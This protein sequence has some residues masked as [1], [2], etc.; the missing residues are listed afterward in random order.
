MTNKIENR[1]K[2]RRGFGIPS[3]EQLEEYELGYSINN[4]QLYI[5][6]PITDTTEYEIKAVPSV[7]RNI[8]I[9]DIITLEN[10]ASEIVIE[11][12]NFIGK[13]AVIVDIDYINLTN[14]DLI[15]VFRKLDLI[16][17]YNEQDDDDTIRLK[18]NGEL[19]QMMIGES[20]KIPIKM[21]VIK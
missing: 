4:N 21:V 7:S 19:P 20:I 18:I 9:K 12:E 13:V 2:L 10:S 5:K 6:V 17:I 15:E 14:N 8:E 16:E 3:L 1:I 11:N